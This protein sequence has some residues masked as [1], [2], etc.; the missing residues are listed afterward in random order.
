MIF[1]ICNLQLIFALEGGRDSQWLKPHLSHAFTAAVNR[2]ATQ[3]QVQPGAQP[4]IR[5]KGRFLEGET[6]ARATTSPAPPW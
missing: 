5:S 4:K 6:S 2:C 3:K 1:V